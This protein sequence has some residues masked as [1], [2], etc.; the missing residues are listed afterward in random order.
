MKQYAYYPGC[1][2]ES[3]AKGYDVS[4]KEVSR[5]LGLELR[6]IE[7][8]NCCGATA[9]FPVDELLAY[10]LVAR[11]LAIA[12]KTGLADFVA[13][14]SACFKNAYF[15]NAYLKQ[16]PDLADHI[17]FAL[18]E[19]NLH[20]NGTLKVRHLIEVFIEDVGLEQ[21]RNKTTHPLTG[22]RV[23]PN[24][25]CQLIRPRRG[26]EDVENPR[27]FEELLSA[28]GAEP[29]EYATKTRCCGSSLIITNRRAALEMIRILLE[30]AINSGAHVIATTCPMCHVNLE[31]YQTQ[32]NQEF[33]TNLS[34]P[35][36][37]F[38]QLMGVA[39]GLSTKHLGID[40]AILARTPM[41]A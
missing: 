20:V 30:D 25:G 28:I 6:E 16:D 37:Y 33:G 13:P 19:D 4:T 11:N 34:I 10:T 18:E 39:L 36:I 26:R 32:V 2:L 27:F 40:K 12:E 9:Y 21:I 3:L 15:T 22:L 14:C 29:V 35:V 8:W 23:A 1:S 7:D 17:N 41:L 38:T 31:V 5:A 24:Y